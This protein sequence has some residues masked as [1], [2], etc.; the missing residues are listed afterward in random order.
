M[1]EVFREH[2]TYW[3]NSCRRPSDGHQC[4]VASKTRS[5]NSPSNMPGSVADCNLPGDHP[6]GIIPWTWRLASHPARQMGNHSVRSRLSLGSPA[7]HG[8]RCLRGGRGHI[9]PPIRK[10]LAQPFWMNL[11]AAG[12]AGLTAQVEQKML[13]PGQT[14]DD[15]E[16]AL[17]SV[18]HLHRADDHIIEPAGSEL[19]LDVRVHTA[20]VDQPIARDFLREEQQKCRAYGQTQG[21]A[22][23]RLDQGMIPVVLEQHGRTAPVAQAIFQRLLKAQSSL[24]T[25]LPAYCSE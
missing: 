9:A 12:T 11:A 16:P 14:Q 17:G 3:Q 6:A 2:R 1:Q 21:Y 15:G 25:P 22:L 18:R 23:N 5:S 19:W 20:H 8:I 10:N 13:V 4:C 7:P 24:G